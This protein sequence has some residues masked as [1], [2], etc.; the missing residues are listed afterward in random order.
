M[1][2]WL[3]A[4]AWKACIRETVSWVRIPL[5]PL[6]QG[7][8]NWKR[9]ILRS[10][11]EAHQCARSSSPAHRSRTLDTFATLRGMQSLPQ[12]IAALHV[13]PE[14]RAVAEDACQHQGCI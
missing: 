10:S 7:E 14:I 1:A 6:L 12:V 3:K 13:Q 4:H 8:R 2:E 5:P 11:C 9:N